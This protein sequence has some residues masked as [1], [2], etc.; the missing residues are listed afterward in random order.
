MLVSP[1]EAVISWLNQPFVIC[2]REC[3]ANQV[4]DRGQRLPCWTRRQKG[5]CFMIMNWSEEFVDLFGYNQ[6]PYTHVYLSMYIYIYICICICICVYIYIYYIYIYKYTYYINLQSYM[7]YTTLGTDSARRQF[8]VVDPDQGIFV[9]FL[10]ERHFSRWCE[11]QGSGN[12]NVDVG[13]EYLMFHRDLKI[14]MVNIYGLP[15]DY[16]WIIYGL[17]MD[18]LWNLNVDVSS[19]GE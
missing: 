12:L 4:C 13:G 5:S 6:N 14:T 3:W 11:S 17:S 8:I 1:S 10:S 16:L 15:M 18:Y 9:S 7:T 2:S 19:H